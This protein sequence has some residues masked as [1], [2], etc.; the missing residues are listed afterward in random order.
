LSPRCDTSQSFRGGGHIVKLDSAKE[1]ANAKQWFTTQQAGIEQTALPQF[2]KM[3]PVWERA[4]VFTNGAVEIPIT[5]D[6]ITIMPSF[7]QTKDRD[8]FYGRQRLLLLKSEK[9]YEPW[10]TSYI[11]QDPFKGNPAQLTAENFLAQQFYGIVSL[12]Q[13]TDQN[14]IFWYVKNGAVTRRVRAIKAGNAAKCNGRIEETCYP[15][16]ACDN[17]GGCPHGECIPVG[18]DCAF[19][20]ISDFSNEPD[21]PSGYPISGTG[22]L[23]TGSG[24]G[25][26]GNTLPTSPAG[27]SLINQRVITAAQGTWLDQNMSTQFQMLLDYLND[28]TD[29]GQDEKAR[30]L[31]TAHVKQLM[32]NEGYRDRNVASPRLGTAEWAQTLRFNM[33]NANRSSNPEEIALTITYPTQAFLI[34]VNSF[35]AIS[36]TI[37]KTGYNGYNDKS[38]AFR[39]TYFQA[40][41]TKSVGAYITLLFANAHE[42]TPPIIDAERAMDTFNNLVGINIGSNAPYVGDEEVATRVLNNSNNGL[43]R[44]LS[45]LGIN[46]EVISTTRL[47]PTNQ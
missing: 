23:F 32:D 40:I 25:G 5:F 11:P 34:Y 26:T 9:G 47:I 4:K 3:Q 6:G 38:D 19:Y 30:E 10:I 41:N 42:T 22:G 13:L 18:R 2:R 39:H 16:A 21:W 45:P 7:P 43:L 24:G 1:I 17:C 35:N 14:P 37:E 27:R 33:L 12:Q 31:I 8:Y 20:C 46:N 28:Q 44:Y 36:M 15:G 29:I